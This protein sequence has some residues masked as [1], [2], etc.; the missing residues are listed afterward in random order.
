[1]AVADLVVLEACAVA[2]A[3]F[4]LVLGDAFPIA[5]PPTMLAQVM[6]A[7]AAIPV[8][9]AVAGLYPAYGHTAVERLRLRTLVIV[10]GFALLILFDYLAQNGQWSR[11]VLLGAAILALVASPAI[12]A[13]VRRALSNS[14][15]WG[16]PAIV[17]GSPAK[18]IDIVETLRRNRDLGWI[19]VA[20]TAD[21]AA[22]AGG[23]PPTDLL[24]VLQ[25]PGGSTPPEDLPYAR[26][27]VV[28]PLDDRQSLWVSVR[29]IGGALALETRRNLLVGRNRLFKRCIDL[30]L[31]AAAV[32]VALPLVA[33]G[34]LAVRL[35]SPGPAFFR[36]TRE[37][38]LGRPFSIWKLRTMRVDA[39]RALDRLLDATPAAREEWDKFMKLRG[40]P[41]VV[42][43]V[44]WFLRRFS[45]DELPQ[46][47][48]VLAG[49]MSL[50]GPRP[51]PSYHA[52]RLRPDI[53]RL[54]QQIRPGITGLWQVEGRSLNGLD[55]QQYF[56][57]YYVRNWSIWLDIHI[58]ANT[59]RT[60]L[61]ARG[62]C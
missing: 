31:A 32:P 14:P 9:F 62:A 46:L 19:P 27:V 1:M 52:E 6:A 20:E 57:A 49:D 56:D 16:V 5:I 21:P 55:R 47:W 40:D 60:V 13:A 61:L 25:E 51:L 10:A 2:A 44:G 50:I 8:G 53:R 26:I 54:R 12:A 3:A 7:V 45:I 23:L 58:L 37:G 59:I 34:A 11:G 30:A 48:N 39:D 38:A 18:R 17:C 29:D 35:A 24:I 36:Q 42:P 4:R 22:D 43:V 28:P 15:F 33:L 41:R